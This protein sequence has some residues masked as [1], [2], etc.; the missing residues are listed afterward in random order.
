MSTPDEIFQRRL[1]REISARKQAEALLEQKSLELFLEA[2]ERQQALDA[3]RDSQQELAW[4]A[5][6][7]A[8][9]GVHNRKALMERLDDI[10]ASARRHGFPV[11]VAFVDLDRFKYVNDRYGHAVGDRL[12]KTI[13]TRLRDVLRREDVVGRYGGDEFILVLQGDAKHELSTQ[14]IERI[15]AAVCEPVQLDGYALTITCSLGIAAFPADGDQPAMLI[16]RAD[17]AMYR[18]KESGRNLSQFYNAEIH[19]RVQERALIESTLPR[20]LQAGEFLLHYQPQISLADGALVGAEALL[21]WQHPELGLLSP[22][23][24]IPFA[25]EST[26][27]NRIG[28]WALNEACQQCAA[29]HQAGL[30]RLRIAVNLSLRQ[31]NGLEL[32]TLVDEALS[33]SGLPADCLELELTES[34][35][36]TN[37]ELT[38]ETLRALHARG[39]HVALDDFGTG[40]SSF[41]YLKQLPLSCLKV[42]RQFVCDLGETGETGEAGKEARAADGE[43]IVRTLVQL[44]HNLGLRVIAEGVETPA[45]LAILRALGCDEIQGWLYSRALSARAFEGI[46]REHHNQDWQATVLPELRKAI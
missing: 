22:E 29:W 13:T 30:G 5:A 4:Q 3:L 14:A 27:I 18:A 37:I 34:L 9:T 1:E 35:M 40:Y 11:W 25:E 43:V 32:I 28:A 2:Q 41:A 10:L 24:F 17:A 15:M 23:R 33:S 31:L 39:V 21:R 19:A 26:L 6:H 45:Q 36:M 7:D 12:L 38:L 8:L 44:A 16:E 42:D 46:A 20:A